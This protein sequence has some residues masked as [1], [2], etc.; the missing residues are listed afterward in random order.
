MAKS[1]S[2]L[3]LLAVIILVLGF[4][5]PRLS[6][7]IA[8]LIW[9][10]GPDQQVACLFLSFDHLQVSSVTLKMFRFVPLCFQ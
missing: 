8:T 4:E 3:L 2:S 10:L 7:W 6:F 9:W 1:K 5:I